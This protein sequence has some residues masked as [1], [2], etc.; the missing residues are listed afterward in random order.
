M[1]ENH[2]SSKKI[3]EFFTNII[4]NMQFTKIVREKKTEFEAENVILVGI[5]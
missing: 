4:K 1:V 3:H 5:S 2:N